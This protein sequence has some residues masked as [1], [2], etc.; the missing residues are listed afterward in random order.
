MRFVRFS[1]A[2]EAQQG[3]ISPKKTAI[4]SVLVYHFLSASAAAVLSP[5]FSS[6]STDAGLPYLGQPDSSPVGRE[7]KCGVCKGVSILAGRALLSSC[8]F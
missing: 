5:A 2:P 7:M 8:V 6:F 1:K 4:A 3:L